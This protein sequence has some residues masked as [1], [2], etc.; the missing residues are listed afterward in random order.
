MKY[1]DFTDS[2][3]TLIDNY[4]AAHGLTRSEV[5][6]RFNELFSGGEVSKHSNRKAH[7]FA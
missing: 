2:T 6:A 5:V 4:C 3:K 7:I 1:S